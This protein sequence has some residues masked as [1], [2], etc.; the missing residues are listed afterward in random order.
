MS[1][2][3]GS[4]TKSGFKGSIDINDITKV[5][6][7]TA[8]VNDTNT[9]I[10]ANTPQKLSTEASKELDATRLYLKEIEVTPLLNAE[11]EIRLGRQ[12]QKGV[13]VARTKMIVANLRLVVNISRRYLNRGMPLLDIIEEG[14]LGLIK[15]VEKFDPEKGFR[16]STYATWWIRQS[17]ERGIMNQARTIRL[18]IHVIKELNTYLKAST[19]LQKEVGHEPTPEEVA[20]MLN[21]P[22]EDVTKIYSVKDNVCSINIPMGENGDAQLVDMIEDEEL[23]SPEQN[24]LGEE[25]Q[26]FVNEWLNGLEEKQRGVMVRRFG[27]QGH[28]K[29]TLEKVGKEL[30]VTRER[31]RQIQI[32]TLE[33]LRRLLISKGFTLDMLLK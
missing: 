29:T 10:V 12:V 26:D 3:H 23:E 18:P 4:V 15:A 33:Q 11:D 32:E 19:Q 21:K 14:N 22:V 16:F 13:V 24:L 5:Q 9:S 6:N 17:I 28:D 31:V 8:R 7:S 2:L 27:L 20:E 30:G 25:V 1:S